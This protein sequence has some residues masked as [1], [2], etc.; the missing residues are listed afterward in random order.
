MTRIS[1]MSCEHNDDVMQSM[2]YTESNSPRLN[3]NLGA[4]LRNS[5]LNVVRINTIKM[6]FESGCINVG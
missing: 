1:I 6:T 4:I 2:T 5:K 3:A